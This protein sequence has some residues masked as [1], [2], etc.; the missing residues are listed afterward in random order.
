MA[1]KSMIAREHKRTKTVARYFAKRAAVK[2]ILADTQASDD[3]KWDALEAITNH[4]VPG[5]WADSRPMT[6]KEM[7]GTLVVALPLSQTDRFSWAL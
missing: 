2:A 7:N 6:D 1:K 5:R 4:V 3:E